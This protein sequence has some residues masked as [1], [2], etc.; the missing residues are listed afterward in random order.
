M[1]FYKVTAATVNEK[2]GGERP[3]AEERDEL[4]VHIS[5]G[6]EEYNL[7]AKDGSYCFI[8][9]MR[10]GTVTCGIVAEDPVD[11]GKIAGR[12]FDSLGI[13]V[14]DIKHSE[15]V[16]GTLLS[17]LNGADHYGFI[18][19]MDYVLDRFDLLALTGKFGR[20]IPFFDN[21]LISDASEESLYK[22]C[23]ELVSN[24]TLKPELD[25]IFAGSK[26]PKAFGH[27]VHY[28]IE[29]DS[30]SISGD[31]SKTLLGALYKNRRL[32][33]RR[34]CSFDVLPGRDL[35]K[36]YLDVLY[37]SC[38]GGAITVNYTPPED[39]SDDESFAPTE[40]ELITT[41]CDIAGKYRNRVLTVFCLPRASEKSKKLFYES[42]GTISIV[43]IK[44]DLS[45]FG[46]SKRF[47]DLLCR[48]N[49]VRPD[50]KLYARLDPDEN[51]YPDDLR[52]IFD[53]WFND[54]LRY[55]VFPQYKETAT[56]RAEAVKTAPKGNAYD[57]LCGMV[58]LAEAKSV[59]KKAL[60]F[61]KVR[62]LF[63]DSATRGERP[64]M[65]M[66]FTGNPGT[67]K[68]TVARLF[69]R[70][71][72]DNDLLS[73]G[74]LVE[75]GRGDLVGRYVGWTA[76]V[77]KEKFKAAMGG[78]L[79]V[80]EAYSLVDDRDGSFGDEAINTIVQEM[81]N[82]REDLVVIFAGYPDEMEGFLNKNPGIRSRVAFH[83][84]F[85]DYSSDELCDIARLIGKS[86]GVTLTDGAIGK[87]RGVFETAR[88]RP[89][90]GNG[91][92]V[93]NVIE[94]SQMNQASRIVNTYKDTFTQS[95]IETI[96][97]EDIEIPMAE[98]DPVRRPI[99][100]TA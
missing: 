25:R 6:T 19:N 90:F 1:I 63:G 79:F 94:L 56:S 32:R 45:D 4:S 22:T 29:S 55:T 46:K 35:S 85:N 83:V 97:E 33:C 44:E 49:H 18:D 64:A 67:A 5:S 98:R 13:R 16:F 40:L 59:I 23:D 89:D 12:L 86:K 26:N 60:D 80:D 66:V 14:G 39:V 99:G 95:D 9:S 10:R 88:L 82:R 47:L 3:T 8:S 61:Y 73:R 75:V 91:R 100:F 30:K 41:L 72:K 70:I 38:T 43:E 15:A 65:H 58:G 17:L 48:K 96:V 11:P 21:L 31:L 84:P 81:E 87:L 54:K 76:K 37:R 92:Y 93:R 53:G 7:A 51:Y 20:G 57:E 34:Y 2:K 71:M 77:V 50:K 36:K 28:L 78:V 69:A 27:P 52:G 62:R 74:H 42:L 24:D 68:T